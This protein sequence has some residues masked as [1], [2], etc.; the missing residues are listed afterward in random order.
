MTGQM[1]VKGSVK[2]ATIASHTEPHQFEPLHPQKNLATLAARTRPV[3]EQALELRKALSPGALGSLRELVRAMS[4]YYSNTIEGQGTHP[5]NIARA[6][7][8]E[9]SERPD[10]AQRQRIA[11]AHIAA[12]RELERIITADG[13]QEGAILR[14]DFLIAAHRSLY[15]QLRSGWERALSASVVVTAVSMVRRPILGFGPCAARHDRTL[16]AHYK[17]SS[18]TNSF[19]FEADHRQLARG[20]HHRRTFEHR[21]ARL[22]APRRLLPL[23]QRAA[24]RPG[25][26]GNCRE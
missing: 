2:G 5:A 21:E 12:E 22:L 7:R 6:L 16:P 19:G 10:V 1:S 11:L 4:S 26:S 9:F 24:R 15:S 23:A 20:R 8:A 25:S 18:G 14:S 17:R 3:V 13:L